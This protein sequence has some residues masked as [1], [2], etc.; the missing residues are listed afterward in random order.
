[1]NS[2]LIFGGFIVAALLIVWAGLMAASPKE[3]KELNIDWESVDATARALGLTRLSERELFGEEVRV[4]RGSFKELEIEVEVSRGHW[5]P[6]VRLAVGF[7]RRL[8]QDLVV[9]TDHADGV[10]SRLRRLREI[11]MDDQEFDRRFIIRGRDPDRLSQVFPEGTRYQLVRLAREVDN[12]RITDDTLFLF[13]ERGL[14]G[15]SLPKLIKKSLEVGQRLYQTAVELGPRSPKL[16]ATHYERATTQTMA[17][18]VPDE[19]DDDKTPDTA[20]VTRP[21]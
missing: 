18:S 17:R 13:A 14:E 12:I 4:L 3:D 10:V 1:M 21:D 19:D 6:Y 5:A 7:P 15:E 2:V 8:A 9:E 11:K 20:P 16:R